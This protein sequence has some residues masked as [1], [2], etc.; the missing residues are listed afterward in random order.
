MSAVHLKIFHA[1]VIMSSLAEEDV[2][3]TQ[4]EVWGFLF[5][6]TSGPHRLNV[7]VSDNDNIWISGSQFL[8]AADVEVETTCMEVRGRLYVVFFNLAHHQTE[9]QNAS[10]VFVRVWPAHLTPLNIHAEDDLQDILRV[11]LV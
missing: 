6:P 1:L 4:Y 9:H 8:F 3:S 7:W 10:Y 11:L 2:I 5:G